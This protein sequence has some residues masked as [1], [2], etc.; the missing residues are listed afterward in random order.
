VYLPFEYDSGT[1][2]EKCDTNNST[3]CVSPR[4]ARSSLATCAASVLFGTTTNAGLSSVANTFATTYV[5]PVPVAPRKH[6][7]LRSRSPSNRTHAS[8]APG[9]SPDGANGARTLE[10][11]VDAPLAPLATVASPRFAAAATAAA[12]DDDDDEEEEDTDSRALAFVTDRTDRPP[13][14]PEDV[15]DIIIIIIIF[16]IFFARSFVLHAATLGRV[17]ANDETRSTLARVVPRSRSTLARE[18]ETRR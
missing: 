11:L 1:Y 8:I 4:Y 13:R 3:R 2:T 10:P 6:T 16:R 7:N 12:D 5:F 17:D 18:R 9:W 14:R 15:P